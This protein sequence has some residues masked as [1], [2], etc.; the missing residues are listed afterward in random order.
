MRTPRGR[1]A[2]PTPVTLQDLGV[3]PGPRAGLSYGPRTSWG[4]GGTVATGIGPLCISCFSVRL[5]LPAPRKGTYIKMPRFRP[6][7]ERVSPA[8]PDSRA[9][10]G[11]EGRMRIPQSLSDR[12]EGMSDR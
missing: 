3:C 1:V 5:G 8:D 7:E 4:S 10:A 11:V 6:S 9:G 12:V 2:P